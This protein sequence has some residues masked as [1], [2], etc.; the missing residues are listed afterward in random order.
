MRL[1]ALTAHTSAVVLQGGRVINNPSSQ[2]GQLLGCNTEFSTLWIANPTDSQDA[3]PGWGHDLLH[4]LPSCWTRITTFFLSPLS[5]LRRMG[6]FLLNFQIRWVSWS[7]SLLT[8]IHSCSNAFKYALHSPTGW[9]YLYSHHPRGLSDSQEG[10]L[11]FPWC[12]SLTVSFIR[13]GGRVIEI[14][15]D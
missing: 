8:I 1:S 6:G 3:Q 15:A 9:L 14:N 4:Y 2:F 10:H 11:Q 5:L 13:E 12:Q 7:S